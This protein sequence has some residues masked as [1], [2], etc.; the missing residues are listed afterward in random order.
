MFTQNK[1]LLNK[2]DDKNILIAAHRGTNGGN[3]IQNTMLAYENALQHGADMIEIDVIMSTD[4]DFFAFHNGQERMVLGADFDIRCMSTNEIEQLR[5]VNIAGEKVNQGLERLEEILQRFKGRCL[6]NIDRAW[7]YWENIIQFLL[8]QDMNDQILLKSKVDEHLLSIL[9]ST[10]KDL[11]Y[12]PIIDTI[13]EWE[14]VK[15]YDINVAAVELIFDSLMSPLLHGHFLKEL[16]RQNILLWVN[17]ITLNDDIVLSALLDD[18]H[19]IAEGYAQAWGKLM[20]MGFDII[21]T[22]WPALLQHYNEKRREKT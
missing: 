16:K 6:I 15:Q 13:E 18:N 7:F 17:A 19:A 1:G 22:D 8:E 12:M 9:E 21:Q 11:M 14:A 20:D 10:G 4:H 3:I 2:L 5:C